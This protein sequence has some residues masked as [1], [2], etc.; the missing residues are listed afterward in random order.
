[1]KAAMPPRVPLNWR[2]SSLAGPRDQ[3][4]SF[5]SRRQSYEGEYK[6]H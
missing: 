4:E 2:R 5:A 6:A 3:T 1:M